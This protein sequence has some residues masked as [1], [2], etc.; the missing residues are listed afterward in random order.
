MSYVFTGIELYGLLFGTGISQ[1]TPVRVATTTNGTLASAYA[2]GQTVDGVVLATGNR[3]LLKDQTTATENGIYTVNASGAPTRAEDLVIGDNAASIEITVTTGTVNKATTWVCTN[4]PG[5]DIVATNSLVFGRAGGAGTV[6]YSGAAV[7][8]QFVRFDGTTGLIQG[9][10]WVTDDTGN[11]QGAGSITFD[12]ATFDLTLQAANQVTSAGTVTIPDVGGVAGDVVIHNLA[13]TLSA[14]TLN[15]PTIN[16]DVFFEKGTF[17]LNLQVTTPTTATAN[18]IIPDLTGTSRNFV[19]DTLAQTLTNKTLTDSTTFFQ[20]DVTP[21]KKLQFQLSGIT[22]A[23]TRTL[24]VPDASTTIVGTDVTQTLTNKT[25]TSPTLSSNIVFDKPTFDVFVTAVDQTTANSTANIP[26][27]GGTT[28]DFV[29]TALAQTISNKS[30]GTNLDAGNFKIVN[31]ATPTSALDAVNKSYVDS[32]SSGLDP[33]ES[34]YVSTVAALPGATY[35]I[36]GPDTLTGITTTSI[37]GIALSVNK[38]VLVKNQADPKQNGIYFVAALPG[39]TTT[40]LT[41]A[42]DQDGTPAGEVSAGNFTFV[43]QGT[44]NQDTG[45]VLQGNGILTLNTDPLNWVLFTASGTIIAGNGLSKTGNTLDVNTT[46]VTTGI[47]SDTVIVRSTGTANQ[48]LRSTGTAGAEA[49]WGT[50]A[51]A[52]TNAV[53]GTLTVPNGGT[54]AATFTSGNLLQGNGTSAISSTALSTAS[55]LTTTNTQTVSNKTFIDNS[56]LIVDDGDNTKV[57]RFEASGITTATTRIL[58][59]PDADLTIV[60]TTTTQTLSN[61]TLTAPRFADLGFIADPAGLAMLIF[62]Q[63][64]TAVNNFQISNAA[65]GNNPTLSVVGTD[66]NVSLDILA[67]GTGQVRHLG[68]AT[69]QAQLALREQT[70]NGTNQVV[71]QTPAALA[72]DWTLTLP[73]DAGTAGYLLRTNGSGVTTWISPPAARVSYKWL[74][75][76]VAVTSTTATAVAYHAWA[77]TAYADLGT[78][79]TVIF[80]AQG[81]TN[82][83]LTVT[84]HDGASSLGTTTVTSGSPAGIYTFTCTKPTS[85]KRLELRVNKSAAGGTSPD[86]FGLQLE[87]TA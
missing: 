1:R 55:I 20:D 78:T 65:T 30:L 57:F 32:V 4:V 52:D 45:W 67:K 18:A 25:L 70:T 10:T 76:Q 41:R 17:D 27:L 54:G 79:M 12:K 6:A 14:K 24:T 81:L 19:F 56:T 42:T 58:T 44:V 77:N 28:Q 23:T 71:I 82:R 59:V 61:K 13:Q 40:N 66:T 16:G 39:G 51:L 11:V 46:G 31:L 68:T 73:P 75:S 50:V 80:W 69:Q 2:A 64:T 26:N 35:T 9:S 83:D 72:A 62:D 5:A 49:A 15:T 33:K 63:N 60:G 8:N 37:D 38:R 21:S 3:I 7:D 53:S 43:E 29:F 74:N 84:V 87:F 47:S 86:I 85:D 34:C 36:A 22:A 48:V